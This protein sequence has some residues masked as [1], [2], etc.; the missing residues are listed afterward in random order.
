[1][2]HVIS[3][4]D[5]GGVHSVKS[6]DTKELAAERVE[7]LISVMGGYNVENVIVVK[8]GTFMEI[9]ES[10]RVELSPKV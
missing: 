3:A 8:G 7:R 4:G 5:R 10:V 2:Y 6:F 9:E 1:M